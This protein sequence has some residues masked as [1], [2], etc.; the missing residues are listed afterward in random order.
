MH[1]A[2]RG[3][4]LRLIQPLI[5]RPI[6]HSSPVVW[7]LQ[8]Q[9]KLQGKVIHHSRVLGVAVSEQRARSRAEGSP[10]PAESY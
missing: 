2:G 9:R 8:L 6:L 1:L 10:S 5:N 4:R 7:I 3:D